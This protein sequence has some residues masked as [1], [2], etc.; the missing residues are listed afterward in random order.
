MHSIKESLLAFSL[1]PSFIPVCR[2]CALFNSNYY[3]RALWLLLASLATL[4]CVYE[5]PKG[6][7]GRHTAMD[8][9]IASLDMS[10]NICFLVLS[11]ARLLS[12]PM[13]IRVS[14]V[15]G[16]EINYL[17][18]L[19]HT[20]GLF[21]TPILIACLGTGLNRFGMWL[22]LALLCSLAP[23]YI[24]AVPHLS[25]LLNS[26]LGAMGSVF[27]T[28]ALFFLSVM[29]YASFGHNLF[30]AN[31]PYHF[32]T[33]GIS[34]WT[35]FRL[36]IFDN[37]ADVWSLNFMGCDQYPMGSILIDPPDG[38][39]TLV[40]TRYGDF[41]LG[42]CT[43]PV[44]Q[45]YITSVVFVSFLFISA[46]VLVNATMAAVVIGMKSSLDEFKNEELFGTQKGVE[47]QAVIG[48]VM[49]GG[50]GSPNPA[51]EVKSQ[52][53]KNREALEMRDSLKIL[54]AVHR[55]WAADD[56]VSMRLSDLSHMYGDFTNPKRVAAEY[57][58]IMRHDLYRTIYILMS[59]TVA[60][61][62]VVVDM[63]FIAYEQVLQVFTFFQV[64]FTV[65][66]MARAFTFSY[67]APKP[68]EKKEW[69]WLG[70]GL[71]LAVL[72]WVPLIFPKRKLFRSFHVLRLLGMLQYFAWIRDLELIMQAFTASFYGI[73]LL[74]ALVIIFVFFFSIAG[75]MLF[76]D[77]DPYHFNSFPKS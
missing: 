51:L 8:N 30:R 38:Y 12:I 57:R 69:W 14:K 71:V 76:K 11:V 77:S 4:V 32:G 54:K 44:A 15:F 66:T 52:S 6:N 65:D 45:P 70:F 20:G 10:I 60:L 33:Y 17:E 29:L 22:R 53:V 41:H 31:D 49:S 40:H 59:V 62:Q 13:I 2:A 56:L 7:F 47:V 3:V 61:L 72:L 58:R 63:D 42:T 55:I 1:N 9:L 35:F 75:V 46:Y 21:K 19:F 67:M 73:V 26:I 50:G 48:N 24:E 68:K 64:L 27:V 28:V 18:L 74:V 25:I 34:F 43:T 37:W 23:S 39:E 16:R 5:A 36:A